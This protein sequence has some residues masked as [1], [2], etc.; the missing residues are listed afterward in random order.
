MSNEKRLSGT[1]RQSTVS[2]K[3]RDTLYDHHETR[4]GNIG[5]G[6]AAGSN[7]LAINYEEF[8][9]Q[10]CPGS[11]EEF[12]VSRMS[13][14]STHG[15]VLGWNSVSNRLYSVYSRTNLLQSPW[16][17]N[18]LRVPGRAGFMSYTNALSPPVF[19]RLGV[20]LLTIP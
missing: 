19:F 2:S 6:R 17:T 16:R 8:V 12:I 13:V 20:E 5:E 14:D 7:A 9:A 4:I 18:L 1:T 15:V 11:S 3:A 10:T